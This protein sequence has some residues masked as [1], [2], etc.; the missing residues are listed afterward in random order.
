MCRPLPEKAAES[1]VVVQG[2]RNWKEFYGHKV[3][4]AT[5]LLSGY[6]FRASQSPV[7]ISPVSEL[8]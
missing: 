5:V 1:M 6:L 7:R 3:R 8:S 2:H 4:R